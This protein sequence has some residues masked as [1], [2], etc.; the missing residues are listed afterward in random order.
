MT[1]DSITE[2]KIIYDYMYLV[3]FG[4]VVYLFIEFMCFKPITQN[5]RTD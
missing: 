3:S 2:H 1:R 5:Y 4:N